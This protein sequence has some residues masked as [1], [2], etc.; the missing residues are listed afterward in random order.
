MLR[1][2]ASKSSPPTMLTGSMSEL[3]Q[4]L[5]NSISEAKSVFLPSEA[6]TEANKDGELPHPISDNLLERLS[7]TASSNLKTPAWLVRSSTKPMREPLKSW[8]KLLLRRESLTW[9]ES[10]LKSL[11]K[12]RR[13][14]RRSE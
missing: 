12:R 4:L 11:R 2:V 3:P 10:L 5:T 14:L 8:E 6:T 7:D 13:R 9:I 1:L